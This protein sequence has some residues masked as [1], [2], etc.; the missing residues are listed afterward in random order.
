MTLRLT[1]LRSQEGL[2]NV[3]GHHRARDSAAQTDDVHVII[4]H[5]L[6]GREMVS[7][8]ACARPRNLVGAHCCANAAAADSAFYLARRNR[9]GQRKYKVRVVV[10]RLQFEGTEFDNLMTCRSQSSA[11]ILL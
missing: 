3:P 8:Q 10:A 11:Q 7:D 5:P 1:E 4:L 2:N 9:P 6:P